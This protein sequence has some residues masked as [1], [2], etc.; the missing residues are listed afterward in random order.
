MDT[1]DAIPVVIPAGT[2][3]GDSFMVLEKIASENH[4]DVYDAKP[5]TDFGLD[6]TINYQARA[7][8]FDGLDKQQAKYRARSKRRLSGRAVLEIEWQGLDVVIYKARYPDPIEIGDEQ[9][10][11]E[12]KVESETTAT[13]NTKPKTAKKQESNRLRQQA[14]RQRHRQNGK[15]PES[16]DGN[17]SGADDRLAENMPRIE[18][19]TPIEISDD[20]SI[21]L[22][23][24]KLLKDAEFR[25][26]HPGPTS[27]QVEKYLATKNTIPV[28]DDSDA[29]ADFIEFKE[30]ELV[31]LRRQHSTF[32]P[33][34]ENWHKHLE[35]MLKE[36]AQLPRGSTEKAKHQREQVLPFW[37]KYKILTYGMNFLPDILTEKQAMLRELKSRLVPLK[38]AKVERDA[39][40]ATKTERKRLA[41]RMKSY[42][43]W[44]HHVIPGTAQYK[45]AI[46]DL[47]SAE[48]KLQKLDVSSASE[49]GNL[50][51]PSNS[52]VEDSLENSFFL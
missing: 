50:G 19:S 31:Y 47:M 42:E 23:M 9:E 10:E 20:Q 1:Q 52:I 43:N 13:P 27:Q 15:Q 37:E 2:L 3:L 48:E 51:L 29:L 28:M 34:I 24:L 14:R 12:S 41:K 32:L 11:E 45:S 22:I 38:Q 7:F 49:N 40:Q 18:F 44:I 46:A 26:E 25:E 36:Q 35:G 8:R 17:E 4:S 30:R 5:L 39:R 16:G 6:M 33:V 21:F